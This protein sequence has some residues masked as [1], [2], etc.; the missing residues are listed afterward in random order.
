MNENFNLDAIDKT[1]TSYKKGQTFGGVVVLR[2]ADGVIFNIGGKNDAYIP[3]SDFEDYDAVK[4]GDRFEVVITN[5]KNEEGLIEASKSLADNLR[6]ANQNALSLRLGSKFSFVA[7]GVGNG[8]MSKMGDYTIIVPF[9][10]VSERY[11]KNFHS[12]VGKQM[13]AV[14]T[15]IDKENKNIVAS[16]KLLQE[17]TRIAIENNFWNIIFVNKVVNGKVARIMPYGAFVSVEG[18]DCFLHISNISYDKLQKVEDV[19]NVGDERQF[20]VIGIDKENKKVEL[21]LKALLEDPK[22]AR[23]KSLETGAVYDAEVVKLLQFGAIVKV[24]NGA[25]GLLHISNCTEDKTKKIYELVKVGDKVRVE[26][27]SKDEETQKIS[28]KLESM[29][30]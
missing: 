12:F 27:I 4:I 28:F 11:V 10:Q 9:D 26:L 16:V 23:V 2:R 22:I 1:F 19:L 20:K 21:S 24:E 13:E 25:T 3:A 8:L 5:Q 15:E 7:T 14:V 18:F 17:Q 29:K 30:E 6:I